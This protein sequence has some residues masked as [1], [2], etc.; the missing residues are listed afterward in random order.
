LPFD[1]ARQREHD[2][3]AGDENEQREDEVV[4][5]QAFPGHVMQLS[6]EEMADATRD[7]P[8]AGAHVGKRPD[9]AVAAYQPEDVETAQRVDRRN[10]LRRR[11][12]RCGDE[13]LGR[14]L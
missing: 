10:P 8:L 4:E 1:Q 5:R 9:G 13:I 11:S 7:R 12:G 3:D 2:R 6:P 14:Q